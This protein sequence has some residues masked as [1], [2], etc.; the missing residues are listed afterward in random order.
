MN[1]N[2]DTTKQLKKSFL[3]ASQKEVYP[4][5]LL[6]N[7]NVTWTSHPK[8][9]VIILDTQ[10]KFD[11]H[12]KMVSGKISKTVGLLCK[13]Q[14]PYQE[15]HLLQYTK[16]LSDPILNTMIF[17]MIKRIL[18]LFTKSWNPFSIMRYLERKSL[19]R[20]RCRVTPITTLV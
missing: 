16:L 17:F 6:N 18:C 10:L 11:D 7:V 4:T 5:L 15:L 1:F 19:P 8:I 3:V 12:L 9:L 14:N 20:T 13:L 2:P